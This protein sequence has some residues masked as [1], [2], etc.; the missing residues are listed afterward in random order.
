MSYTLPPI[1]ITQNQTAS[2]ALPGFLG[3][4]AAVKIVNASPYLLQIS[5]LLGGQDYLQPGEANVWDVPGLTTPILAT[6]LPFVSSTTVVP[7]SAI[8]VTWYLEGERPQGNYPVNFNSLYFNGGNVGTASSLVNDSS[9]SGT[10]IIE[11]RPAAA[12]GPYF[13]VT[14]DGTVTMRGSLT[15]AFKTGL[16]P[17][18]VELSDNGNDLALVIGG[19]AGPGAYGGY[20][21]GAVYNG[22]NVTP[23][24]IAQSPGVSPLSWI[25]GTGVLHATAP[26][27]LAA[28]NQETGVVGMQ[29]Y[30]QAGHNVS[31][32][33]NF[34]T[35]LTNV[36]TSITTTNLAAP[37]NASGL[38]FNSFTIYG[39][40]MFWT[41]GATADTGWNVKY[42]TVGNCLLAVDTA[43]HT[44]DHHCDGC[45]AVRRGVALS[46]VAVTPGATPAEHAL[47]YTCPTCGTAEHYNAAL[48]AADEADSS[49]QGSG[50][51]ATTR[52]AQATLIRALMQALN[53]EV[54]S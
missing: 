3:G 32:M 17:P 35:V 48:G 31:I 16:L 41:V 2:I 10:Q 46:E 26:V 4:I 36:P 27:T 47:F 42:T 13:M 53:I 23:F 24:G 25:D 49:P 54:A 40:N 43:A 44:F 5:N 30:G 20:V 11:A 29:Q 39:M 18:S 14:N 21:F 6:A 22:N 1:A 51:Y 45:G 15:I 38:N 28:G 8:V 52:G 12:A 34:K 19:L 7:V 37:N 9:P 33:A 50:E